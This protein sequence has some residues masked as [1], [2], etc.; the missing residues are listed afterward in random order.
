MTVPKP[1]DSLDT[2][3][4]WL[5]LLHPTE[6]EMGLQRVGA[7]ADRLNLRPSPV[8]LILVGGT[9]GKG[10]T[11][12]LLSAIYSH[13]GYKVGTY[14]SP[15]IHVFNE[16]M[17]I[18]GDMLDDQSIVNGL[19]QIESRRL[20]ETLTYFEYTT[21]A[22]MIAF[23]EAACDLVVMEVG[24]GGRLD[25]TN[26]WDCDCAIITSIALDH[27]E[28]LGDTR[29]AIA[30]EK[31]A[32]G[33]KDTPLIVGDV[34]P[35]SA[36]EEIAQQTQMRLQYINMNKLPESNLTGEHQRRNAACA[37]MAIDALQQQF[38]VTPASI[39]AGL[40]SVQLRGRFEQVVIDGQLTILDVAH[41][42]AAAETVADALTAGYPN[43]RVYAVF[44]ALKDKDLVGIVS[45]LAP[46]V[47][48][49]YCAELSVPRA[50]PLDIITQ[51][52]E[53]CQSAPVTACAS[54][55]DA[56]KT[57]VQQLQQHKARAQDQ[58]ALVLVA[59]SFATLSDLHDATADLSNS[60]EPVVGS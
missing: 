40:K 38:V 37:L 52:L 11:V 18:N 26:L 50:A 53:Q 14:T 43:H 44:S 1:D 29:D 28:Y 41:N 55:P 35:P 8:P 3:L 5:E 22:A 57:A 59:G 23:K 47:S 36:I 13:A 39:D 24:L 15:H 25:A 56:W 31:V 30:R 34:N 19:H 60:T 4:E 21:L 58:P 12:A 2:W 54:I 10:S 32:I 16:R 27:Q 9:N 17:R 7:V 48:G 20:P 42:P 45:K 33:R 51:T 46:A 6:I 49:W